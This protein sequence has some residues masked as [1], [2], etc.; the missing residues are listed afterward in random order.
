MNKIVDEEYF[1]LIIDNAI[2]DSYP[3]NDND[4]IFKINPK[5]SIVLVEKAQFDMCAL[6]TFPYSFFPSIFTLTSEISTNSNIDKVQSNPNFSLFGQGVLVAIIDTGIDYQHKAFQY[7]DGSTRIA[8][9]W[10]QTINDNN[11]PPEGFFYGS[12][13]NKELI[14]LALK[15]MVPL[16][17]VPSVDEVG[18]GTMIAGIAGGSPDKSMEFSGVVPQ[19]EFVIV[20]L[21]PA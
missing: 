21:K 8:S 3:I 5:H 16:N 12:E 15:N 7:A 17:V 18:H 11:N 19:C 1:D 2:I 13:Y 6:G 4:N 9:I 20:K 10:D 14:N